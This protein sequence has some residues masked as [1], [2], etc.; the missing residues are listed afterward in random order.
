MGAI[1]ADMGSNMPLDHGLQRRPAASVM[2]DGHLDPGQHLEQFARHVR[3]A[4]VA[5]R[6][7]LDPARLALGVGD[8]FGDGRRRHGWMHHHH[9]R[10][11]GNA[12]DR[13]DVAQEIEGQPRIERRADRVRRTDQQQRVAV[14]R[15]THDRLGCYV[16]G[17]AGP[18][19]DDERLPEPLRQPLHHQP[20][21]D[22][23]GAAR[24]KPDDQAHR[25]ARIALCPGYSRHHREQR[26]RSTKA[27]QRAARKCH[28]D[29]SA[30]SSVVGVA[31]HASILSSLAAVPPSIAAR[32]AS[33]SPGVLRM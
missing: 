22:V 15:R 27:K 3:R 20:R 8:E 5:G 10:L 11:A 21:E 17:G 30:P 2:H 6:S 4:A 26:R 9:Q 31:A 33:L 25:G 19:L 24:G 16:A 13:R 14:G 12:R 29:P 18:V 28:V 7:E 1:A 32:S 23:V